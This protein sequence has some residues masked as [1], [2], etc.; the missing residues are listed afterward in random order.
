MEIIGID[1]QDGHGIIEV[2]VGSYIEALRLRKYL[3][4]ATIAIDAEAARTEEVMQARAQR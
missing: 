1:V 4:D 3:K 2:V